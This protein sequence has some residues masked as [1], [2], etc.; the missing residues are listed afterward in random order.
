MQKTWKIAYIETHYYDIEV[1]IC[2][3]VKEYDEN[4]V[5]TD[6]ESEE[7]HRYNGFDTIDDAVN[8]VHE[9]FPEITNIDVEY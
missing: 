3:E 2:N 9:M 7:L 1:V 4:G 5:F 8:F 6:T